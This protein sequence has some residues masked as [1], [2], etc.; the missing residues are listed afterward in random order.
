M[1][2]GIL[3]LP[4]FTNYGGIL[5]AFALQTVL[6]RMGHEV[7]LVERRRRPVKIPLWK[8]PFVYCKRI[9]QNVMG[10][11]I[12]L[13]YERKLNKE[14]VIS[15]K[16]TSEFVNRYVNRRVVKDFS[17]IHESD[18]DAII[19]GSDQVWRPKYFKDGIE[20]AY[21][22]F[23]QGWKS[24][25][26]PMRFLSVR[27]NGSIRLCKQN[28]AKHWRNSLIKFRLE[29]IQELLYVENI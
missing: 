28:V 4:L 20:R 24:N 16:N 29:K 10:H 13:L 5:Q 14:Y 1:R 8:A 21:L 17:E 9:I 2:I 19:V 27:M 3:T 25:V 7:C 15:Q 23:A 11:P 12:P 18:F 6:E 26:W 22:D